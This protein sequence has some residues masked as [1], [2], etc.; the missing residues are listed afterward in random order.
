MVHEVIHMYLHVP[1]NFEKNWGQQ[2]VQ[3]GV[4]QKK[5]H[6]RFC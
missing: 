3:N 6:F 5:F 1:Q 2:N 4:T